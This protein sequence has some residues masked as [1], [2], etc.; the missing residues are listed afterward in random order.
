[1]TQDLIKYML[2]DFDSQYSENIN[3]FLT[4]IPAESKL[5][6]FQALKESDITE[7]QVNDFLDAGVFKRLG[8]YIKELF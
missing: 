7:Q 1:M 8:K 5:L 4:K 6:F 2:S 3:K